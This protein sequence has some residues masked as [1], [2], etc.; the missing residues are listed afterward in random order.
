[1]FANLKTLVTAHAS[2]QF[3]TVRQNRHLILT[4]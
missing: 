1:M 2:V 4:H 3:G